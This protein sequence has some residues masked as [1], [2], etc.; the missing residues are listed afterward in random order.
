M[1]LPICCRRLAAVIAALALGPPALHGAEQVGLIKIDGAI[2]P[3]TAT[4]VARAMDQAAADHDQCLII[5]LD[6]PGGLLDS[7]RIIVEKLFTDEV[8]TVD[9]Q[10]HVQDMM[11][12]QDH[13]RRSG[14]ALV[15]GEGRGRFEE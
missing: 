4:Y 15:S 3:A 14:I 5:Q 13:G 12:E 8:P 10:L 1:S 9:V 7:T 11:L 6:T 2:G